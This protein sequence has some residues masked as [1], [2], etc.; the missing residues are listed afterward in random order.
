MTIRGVV[1][2]SRRRIC[3]K[4]SRG[5]KAEI[6]GSSSSQGSPGAVGLNTKNWDKEQALHIIEEGQLKCGLAHACLSSGAAR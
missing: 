6:K 4:H 1:V 2:K 3:N 5:E